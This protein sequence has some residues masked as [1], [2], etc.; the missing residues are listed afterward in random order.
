MADAGAGCVFLALPHPAAVDVALELA[1]RLARRRHL[2]LHAL[3][4]EA[5][6]LVTA[7]ALP[8][9]HEIDRHSGMRHDFGPVR[10]AR[11]VTRLALDCERRLRQRAAAER[12]D[13][14]L[15]TVHEAWFEQALAALS[16][17]DLLLCGSRAGWW[18]PAGAATE[19][20]LG[21]LGVVRDGDVDD[22]TVSALAADLAGRGGGDGLARTESA[23]PALPASGAAT[24]LDVLV[25]SRQR[26]HAEGAA[27]R[28]FLG[29]PQRLLIVL[30]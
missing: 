13:L 30:P 19:P 12:L 26:A 2:R 22:A 20:P 21:R 3:V 1:V 28:R 8:F 29:Q 9:V 24:A 6:D 18:P 15:E 27:L 23:P 25:V 10:A 7:G 17:T 14:A 11:A 16:A 4:R 5:S